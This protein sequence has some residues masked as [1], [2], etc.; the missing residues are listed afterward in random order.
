MKIKCQDGA[1]SVN[2]GLKKKRTRK[3]RGLVAFFGNFIEKSGLPAAPVL[4]LDDITI[5][6]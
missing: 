6:P 5:Q 2:I 3:G 1:G 4:L